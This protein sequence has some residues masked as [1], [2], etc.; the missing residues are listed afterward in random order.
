MVELFFDAKSSIFER[1][2]NSRCVQTLDMIFFALQ[3]RS[4]LVAQ[5]AKS[6]VG[7][8]LAK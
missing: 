8:F 3:F 1:E 4:K 7:I 6:L 2:K 5:E